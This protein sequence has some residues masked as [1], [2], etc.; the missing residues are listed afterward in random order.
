MKLKERRPFRRKRL[1]R[2]Q[3]RPVA[4]VSASAP[5]ARPSRITLIDYTADSVTERKITEPEQCLPYRQSDSVTWIN[6]DGLGDRR[7]LEE[8]ARIMGLHALTL[9]DIFNTDLR[10]K[11][12]DYGDYI[13]VVAKMLDIDRANEQ[14]RVD[15]LS[16]VLGHNFVISVQEEAGDPFEPVRNRI[17]TAAGRSRKAGADYLAYA[18]LD[19]IVDQYFT[20]ADWIGERIEALDELIVSEERGDLMQ[21]LYTLKRGVI[22]LRKS[23]LPLRE[24]ASGL[25]NVESDLIRDSTQPYL[26][27]LYDHVV[28]VS[29]RIET[30]RDLLSSLQDAY[31][32]TISN[33]TNTVMKIIAVFS[34]IFLPLTF[35]TG[36][37]GMNFE[38]MPLIHRPWGFAISVLSM[39]GIVAAMLL[40]F[41]YKRWL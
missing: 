34:S 18:L 31:L 6:V 29:D 9:E 37:F 36:V 24:V 33:R 13:Y 7:T 32:S 25:R 40:F 19:V 2:E 26:R 11:I 23:I 14:I 10:P 16:L 3:S 8:L 27:D 21:H 12:E 20:V 5:S 17:R 15:Q 22:F 4:P 1:V 41:R 30:C 39:L 38:F 28:Q 35:I